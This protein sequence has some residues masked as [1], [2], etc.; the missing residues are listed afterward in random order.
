MMTAVS[1]PRSDPIEIPVEIPT[2]TDL[3]FPKIISERNGG[4][5]FRKLNQEVASARNEGDHGRGI[6]TS[7]P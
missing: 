7:R 1:P 2:V 3:C 5:R 6:A 4:C